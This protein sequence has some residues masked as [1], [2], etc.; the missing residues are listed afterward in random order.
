MC[1][2]LQHDTKPFP[3]ETIAIYTP[4]QLS[5][6]WEF[7]WRPNLAVLGVLEILIFATQLGVK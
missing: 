6:K 2:T 1:S 7:P 5:S 4:V 3:K